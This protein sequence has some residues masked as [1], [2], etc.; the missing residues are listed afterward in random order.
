MKT[1]YL[2]FL[3]VFLARVVRAHEHAP[4][5]VAL[6]DNVQV[7]FEDAGQGQMY[8]TVMHTGFQ[9][10]DL[11]LTESKLCDS[12][13]KQYSGYLDIEKNKHLFFWFFE[14]RNTPENAPVVL[15]INGGPGCSTST[16][17]LFEQGP[18]RIAN[19][20][21][22]TTFNPYSWTNHANIIFLDQPINTGYSYAD[23]GKTI[24]TTAAAG[25]DVYAFLE[26]FFEKFPEYAKA[27]FHIGGE[28]YAGMY[29]PNFANI[30]F[31]ANQELAK[32]ANPNSKKTHINLASI[33]LGNG[34]TDP[35][36]QLASIPDYACE[37][38]FA[39]YRPDDP[40]CAS[41]RSKVPTCQ[42]L[43]KSCYLTGLR[44]ACVGAELYCG[45][46]VVEPLTAGSDINPYD[47]RQE[48]ERSPDGE[49][50]APLCYQEMNWIE[51][52]MNE[53]SVKAALGA[54][55]DRKFEACSEGVYKAFMLS[56]DA[57]HNSAVFLPEL[58]DAGV[59]LLVY[60]GNA[61]MMCNYMG[62]ERWVEA[63]PTKF[64]DDFK[65]TKAVS[66][67]LPESGKVI[68]EVRSAGG[69]GSSAG[70]VTFVNVH[71]AGH[72]AAHDQPEA[73]LELFT[74]WIQNTPL[75][76]VTVD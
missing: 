22:N 47:L 65:Q 36:I 61:D 1:S 16:N 34:L 3:S 73:A 39:I 7:V 50:P 66:W 43:I 67:I 13:V 63:L 44:I 25:K 52:W 76:L 40:R 21:K 11:S 6:Q 23:D 5:N 20:G 24:S 10:Y 55:L 54:K 14:A 68:G 51:T 35:Y 72:M 59:R 18:C 9:N 28:S 71:N 41:L 62:N 29:V 46:Y 37:G 30:I 42:R 31:K 74:N 45:K 4:H 26:L 27:P 19:N 75:T 53:A 38:P 64:T 57:M 32:T 48:C 60:A 70:N 56:G 49:S 17:L 33:I 15:W 8:E 12:T 69:L 58:I 2:S